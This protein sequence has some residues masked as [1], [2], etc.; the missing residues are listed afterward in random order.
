MAPQVSK[1]IVELRLSMSKAAARNHGMGMSVPTA[2]HGKNRK[3]NRMFE[4]IK[5]TK[6][7]A[8]VKNV[9]RCQSGVLDGSKALLPKMIMETSR[10]IPC[11]P[12]A[13]RKSGSANF[14]SFHFFSSQ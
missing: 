5:N 2:S 8:Q 10:I 14:A 7:N 4:R 6:A 9:A 13:A 12:C 1:R 3:G 11:A